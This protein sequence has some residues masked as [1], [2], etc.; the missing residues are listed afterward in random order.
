ME[1]LAHLAEGYFHVFSHVHLS[2]LVKV[3]PKS[4]NADL[5][6]RKHPK[7]P[8]QNSD[9]HLKLPA[10]VCEE[11]DPELPIVHVMETHLL[12]SLIVNH[13]PLG[14]SIGPVPFPLI[15]IPHGFLTLTRLVFS[16]SPVD[17]L[18]SPSTD[19]DHNPGQKTVLPVMV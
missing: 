18:Y 11:L 13:L 9:Q 14:I 1:F 10:E 6:K 12:L 3:R 19:Y 8:N 16:W 2:I 5:L 4:A 7:I 15:F 17:T